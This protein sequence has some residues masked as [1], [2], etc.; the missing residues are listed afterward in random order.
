MAYSLGVKTILV[1]GFE[2][3]GDHASNPTGDAVRAF[4]AAPELR[5]IGSFLV[6]PVT[7]RG[8]A[9]VLLAKRAR[10][11]AR[12]VI[13]FGL[14]PRATELRIERVA[15]NQTERGLVDN[16]GEPGTGE[17]LVSG[18]PDRLVTSSLVGDGV[19]D[20]L[21]QRR[22]PVVDS[23]DPG[24]Y[25]CNAT[26]YSTLLAAR[27]GGFASLFVHVPPTVVTGREAP[28]NTL[29]DWIREAVLAFARVMTQTQ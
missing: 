27:S 29:H 15:F 22:I 8:A 11:H 12:G 19:R 1:T 16:A 26:Y 18:A 25:V 4:F 21:V 10:E 28:V 23:D 9:Q 6:L 7:W 2:V 14:S 24:R 17:A 5:R 3:F 13:S 20:A